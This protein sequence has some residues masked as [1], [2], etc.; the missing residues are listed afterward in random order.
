VG[1]P[2]PGGLLKDRDC[3]RAS[4]ECQGQNIENV[5]LTEPEPA[6]GRYRAVV[7]LEKLNGATAPVRVQMSTRIGQRAYRMVVELSPG[8]ATE[9][10]EF[11]FTL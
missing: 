7:R 4:G 10:R 5:F 2:T 1:E 11:A 3:P 8:T 9:E 6:R